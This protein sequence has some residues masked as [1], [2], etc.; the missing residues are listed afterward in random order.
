[1]RTFEQWSVDLVA[2]HVFAQRS[3]VHSHGSV[4]MAIV[5]VK[6][7]RRHALFAGH[8]PEHLLS[9]H[10][11]ESPFRR[12]SSASSLRISRS[13]LQVRRAPVENHRLGLEIRHQALDAA[14]TAHP[15]LFEAAKR[16]TKVR[17]EH[18]VTDRAGA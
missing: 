1:L 4:G 7:L 10:N 14:L 5:I 9:A 6:L 2:L 3:D 8:R 13:R 15:G 12:T 17:S 11:N 18:I 16:D